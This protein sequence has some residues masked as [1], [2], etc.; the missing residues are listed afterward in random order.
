MFSKRITAL[1]ATALA[2]PLILAG[3]SQQGREGGGGDGPVELSMWTHS[4]GNEGEMQVISRMISDF[5][6]SQEDYVVVRQDFPQAA[7]NDSVQGAAAS[8]D[9]PCILDVDGPVMPTWAW[10][11]WL[12]PS[13]LT[14]A[15]VADFIPST[16][17][18]YN[19]EIY[20][21]G[22]WDATT[23]MFSRTS[24]LDGLGI[25]IP[26]ADSPWSADEFQEAQDAILASGDF[27]YAID[28]GPGWAD[29]W[30]PYAY[31][32]LLQSFGG[33]LIDRDTYETADGF[34]NS[35][36]AIAF[37]EWFQAQVEDG[38][39][40]RSNAQDRTEFINGQ[41]A[42]QYNG[43]WAFQ[44][45]SEAFDDLVMFPSPDFGTGSKSGVGSWQY[46]LTSNC[47]DAQLEG[48]LEYLKFTM[49]DQ[50]IAEFSDVTSLIPATTTAWEQTENGWY[51]PDA[52]AQVAAE[53]AEA[54]GLVRPVTPAYTV[55][56]RI[57]D[58]Q[59]RAIIDGVSPEEALNRAV[60]EIDA[61]IQ[62]AGYNN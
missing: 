24:I 35:P 27:D 5:N 59:L 31:A 23:L 14:D 8:G 38:Y 39:A 36:E 28:W 4:A 10:N 58:E 21:V 20:S 26:T 6:E 51:G 30:W 61:D 1:T 32:P 13:G 33:D 45:N 29:E 25:R 7:Y 3:C 62:S 16:I 19:D 40:P 55:M 41:V 9:L 17:G 47:S 54:Y 52:P 56:S 60:T 48:G 34:L 43:N 2:A 15:D 22:Y 18:R 53:I 49:D 50:Y 46:S 57:V 11:G 44:E 12:V 42:I 37:G